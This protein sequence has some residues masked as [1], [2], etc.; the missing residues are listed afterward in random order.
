MRKC[1]PSKRYLLIALALV[2]VALSAQMTSWVY[3]TGY[4]YRSLNGEHLTGYDLNKVVNVPLGSYNLEFDNRLT[5]TDRPMPR[6]RYDR[7]TLKPLITLSRKWENCSGKIFYRGEFF[8]KVRMRDNFLAAAFPAIKRT[9]NQQTGFSSDYH[10]GK[11]TGKLDARHRTYYYEP[12]FDG[13]SNI[14]QVNNLASQV[15]IGYNI[16][17]P[18]TVFTT[19]SFKSAL[20]KKTTIYDSQTAGLGLKLNHPITSMHQIQGSA[21]IQWLDGDRYSIDKRIIDW[22][23][24]EFKSTERLIPLLYNFRYVQMVSQQ[25]MGFINYDN[26]SFYDREQQEF[27]FNSHFLRGSLKYTLP[28]DLS[29]ASFVEIGAKYAPSDV[30]IHKSS[31]WMAKTELKVVKNLYLG[32]GINSMT[33]RLTRYEGIARYFFSPWSEIFVN[34]VYTDDPE[35]ETHFE[36]ANYT[37]YTAAGVRVMF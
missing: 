22:I 26:R 13:D 14:L 34:Y 20:D 33:E 16:I 28:Y 18:L 10:F 12:Q 11:L 9:Y 23:P 4:H 21:M 32:A 7:L 15:E 31:N 1:M 35:S 30:L 17:Q 25:L 36:P 37:T 5:Y 6:E 29:N 27:L 24:Y 8:D 19:A 2:A 3:C